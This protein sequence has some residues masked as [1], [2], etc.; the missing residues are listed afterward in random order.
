MSETL[1]VSA[2]K[3]GTVIDH[4]AAGQAFRIIRLLSLQNSNNKVT[5]GLHLP[6][7]RFGKKDLIKIESRVLTES[8]ANE[9]VVFSPLATINVIEN[10]TVI[11]KITTHLPDVMK[12]VFICPNP[13]C[14][15]QV[16]AIDSFFYITEQKQRVKLTCHYCE[17]IFDRDQ[18]KV[19]I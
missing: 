4:I 6:S 14:I 8:E 1:P 19:N 3:N 13:S 5:I 12:K 11:K 7:K 18:L 9:I 15:T 10:Y 16:E 2:I 17:K